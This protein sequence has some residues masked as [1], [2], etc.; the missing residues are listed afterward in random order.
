MRAHSYPIDRLMTRATRLAAPLAA[1]LLAAC[2]PPP[3]PPPPPLPA[4]APFPQGVAPIAAP[5][6][7]WSRE[8]GLLLR[9]AAPVRV[10]Y[11]GMRLA[12]LQT[13]GDSLQVRCLAC[14]GAP[15]GWTDRLKVIWV[16]ST[17]EQARGGEIA[18][19]VLAVRQA[20]LR[21]DFTALRSAMSPMFVHGLEGRE[22][23]TAAVADLQGPRAADLARVPSLLDRGVA[24]VPG[25]RVWAAPPEFA[26]LP[27]YSDLRTG[28]VNG[29]NGWEWTFLLRPG[30]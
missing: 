24:P 27:G 23:L 10:P 22:G 4:L 6:E 14:P 1:A 13:A 21:R 25:T 7:V 17:P 5:T 30:R 8:A 3:P 12:V 15:I 9:G 26:T 20:A 11:L 29:E 18:E 2:A 28:F 19:F 16:A